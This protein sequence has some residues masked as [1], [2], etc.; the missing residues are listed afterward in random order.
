M[1]AYRNDVALNSGGMMKIQPFPMNSH[2]YPCLVC[3][4]G[5]LG[6]DETLTK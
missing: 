1:L 2:F 5:F 3:E 4:L 6:V